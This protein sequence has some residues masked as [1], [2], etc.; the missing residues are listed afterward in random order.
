MEKN[1]LNIKYENTFD[2]Y[3]IGIS[4]VSYY[5]NTTIQT[6][7]IEVTT[8]VSPKKSM[9]FI[10]NKTNIFRSNDLG[11]N[12][13]S[14]EISILP[15][16]IYTFKYSIFPFSENY[17]E[18]KFFRIEQLICDLEQYFLTLEFSDC[19]CDTSSQFKKIQEIKFLSESIIANAN[20]CRYEVAIELYK[21]AQKELEKLN[22]DCNGV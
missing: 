21:I 13:N 7:T 5:K 6:P 17:V 22:K 11:I 4:D 14:D 2:L 19:K 12:C 8:P 1:I 9:Q 3:S 20:N 18:K 10:P 16:G 15:D